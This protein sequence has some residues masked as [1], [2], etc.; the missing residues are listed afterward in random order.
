MP[1]SR[2]KK[3]VYFFLRY[4]M[5]KTFIVLKYF[6]IQTS[7]IKRKYPTM[8]VRIFLVSARTHSISRYIHIQTLRSQ[9][10]RSEVS[11]AWNI[12]CSSEGRVALLSVT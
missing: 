1:A 12:P 2:R 3:R 11:T 4:F 10:K 8:I 5:F 7:A 9:A 6:H